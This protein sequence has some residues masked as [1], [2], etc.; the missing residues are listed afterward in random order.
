MFID[1]SCI[2]SEKAHFDTSRTNHTRLRQIV[3]GL[4]KSHKAW[5]NCT[6]PT[7]SSVHF[8]QSSGKSYKA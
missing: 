2:Q 1:R 3:Q 8:L 4:D 5:T 7:E 6:R